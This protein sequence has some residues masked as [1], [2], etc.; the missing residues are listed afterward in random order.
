M[1]LKDK[2][3]FYYYYFPLRFYVYFCFVFFFF[4][5]VLYNAMKMCLLLQFSLVFFLSFFLDLFHMHNYLKIVCSFFRCRDALAHTSKLHFFYVFRSVLFVLMMKILQT[6]QIAYIHITMSLQLVI[7]GCFHA[8]FYF[9][10]K[11]FY[12]RF[13]FQIFFDLILSSTAQQYFHSL[14]K[15]MYNLFLF[16][17]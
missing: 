9:F 16:F 1:L 5:N 7:V 12:F 14:F 8:I 11:L 10:F 15:Y 13:L 6:L 2:Y 17:L 3:K 4:T